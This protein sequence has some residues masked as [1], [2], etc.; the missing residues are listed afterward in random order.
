MST[1]FA[2]FL[3]PGVKVVES[4]AGY[5]STELASFATTYMIVSGS[6][7]PFNE[8]TQV[9][10]YANFVETFGT[11]PSENSVKL[12]FRNN[13]NGVLFC[14]RSA[15]AP[16]YIVSINGITAGNY[17]LSI[18]VNGATG[19]PATVA[20]LAGDTVADVAADMIAAVN[21][22]AGSVVTAVAGADTDE[23]IIRLDDPTKTL[24]VTVT[25]GNMTATSSTP[26]A[27]TASDYITT[28]ENSFEY[29]RWAAGFIIAPEAFQT[30]TVA[31]DRL[32]VGNAMEALAANNDW[33]ALVD[34][35]PTSDTVAELQVDSQQYAT[36]KGHLAFY[37]PY[38]KDLDNNL[39][40]PSAAVAAIAN[41]RYGNDGFQ[42]PIGGMSYKLVGVTGPV[43]RFKNQEQ[44]VLNPLGCNLIR[45]FT[46]EGTVIWGM[47]TRSSDALY[48]FVH[49]RI[50]M[51]VL[52]NT[53]RKGF[54]QY[55]F[56]AIDGRG[57]LLHRIEE[58]AVSICRKLFRGNALFGGSEPEAFEVECSF[59]NNLPDDLEDGNVLCQVYVAPAPG[60]EK[61]LIATYRVGIGQVQEAAAAGQ[62]IAEN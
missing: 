53:M 55:P 33:M 35:A 19:I 16:R 25:T 18:V 23:L 57:V 40:P 45:F 49:T 2:S 59:L 61:L 46:G 37:A 50:I 44:D 27:P 4:T 31:N 3:S 28:I 11:S 47:R 38:L 5:R 58:T 39:V 21:A 56:S 1:R 20:V 9:T 48:R 42:E 7:G 10:S 51:N 62:F 14:A 6:T 30:L 8:P 34:C 54:W 32:A 24:A 41:K 13:K 26:T 12:Y 15:I 36:A 60:L 29:D 17:T 52:N 43:Y 22:A